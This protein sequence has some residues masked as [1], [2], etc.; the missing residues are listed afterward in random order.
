M[1]RMVDIDRSDS[2]WIYR[3]P[4]H[5]SQHHGVDRATRSAHGARTSCATSSRPTRMPTCSVRVMRK[6][7]G[8]H[9]AAREATK[10]DTEF[11]DVD[12]AVLERAPNLS[13]AALRLTTARRLRRRRSTPPGAQQRCGD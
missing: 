1:M 5:K 11:K 2:I 6:K 4:S 9:V 8:A 3:P 7:N 10:T 12:A 13:K